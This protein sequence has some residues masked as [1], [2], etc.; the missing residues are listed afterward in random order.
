M[1]SLQARRMVAAARKN[2][3]FLMEALWTLFIPAVR[4]ALDLVAKGEIGELHTIK[5]NFGFKMHYDPRSRVYNKALGGGSLL[6]I[7]IYPVLLS[8]YLFGRPADENIQ[9]VAT[10]GPTDV[11][12]SCVF[13]FLCPENR[14]G[15]VHSTV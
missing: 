11:D 5:S 7:G 4:H 6:D 10:F 3:V 2:R 8:T 15:F 14:L 12:E 9:A 1:N 13:T